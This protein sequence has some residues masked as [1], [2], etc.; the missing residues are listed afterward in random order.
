[1]YGDPFLSFT[2]RLQKVREE[3]RGGGEGRGRREREGRGGGER[4]E[5]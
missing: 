2:R 4:G 3:G 5:R 1:M